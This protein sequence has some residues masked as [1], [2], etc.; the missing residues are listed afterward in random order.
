MGEG[1]KFRNKLISSP[2]LLSTLK[3][4][5]ALVISVLSVSHIPQHLRR[6]FQEFL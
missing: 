5:S 1:S 4:V 3:L 6:V 2:V